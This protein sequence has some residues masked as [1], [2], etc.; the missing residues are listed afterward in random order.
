[1]LKKIIEEF[2]WWLSRLGTQYICGINPWPHLV[3]Q[4]SHAAA[5]SC[6]GCIC[7]WDQVLPG[8]HYR[9][10]NF[11]SNLT[12]SRELPFTTDAAFSFFAGRGVPHPWYMEIPR[13]GFQSELQLLAYTT[14]A[15]TQDPSC[16]C[17]LYHSSWQCQIL[18]PLNEAR[19]QTCNFMVPSWILFRC[20]KTGA[21]GTA[22]KRK[23]EKKKNHKHWSIHNITLVITRPTHACTHTNTHTHEKYKTLMKEVK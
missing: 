3:G 14:A 19:D 22:L 13:L 8:L 17:N 2:P 10:A 5:S 1:M 16:I 12:P 6:I 20:A 23:K 18:N 15:A 11:S 7:G 9:P 4:W 21:P